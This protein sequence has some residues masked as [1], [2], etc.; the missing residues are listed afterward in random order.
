MGV[1]E[2]VVS[3]RWPAIMMRG[4][5]SRQHIL[6]RMGATFLLQGVRRAF[7][8][9]IPLPLESCYSTFL[10][11]SGRPVTMMSGTVCASSSI[12]RGVSLLKRLMC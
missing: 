6:Q 12:L 8:V 3:L 4:M 5:I 9:V 1:V 11:R 7:R 10:Q 2:G